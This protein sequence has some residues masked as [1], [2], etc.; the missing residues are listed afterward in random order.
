MIKTTK[1][2]CPVTQILRKSRP[3]NLRANTEE[4]EFK[5][6]LRTILCWFLCLAHAPRH[7]A[8]DYKE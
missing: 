3:G 7:L 6:F 4:F 8:P 2:F 5:T 1:V